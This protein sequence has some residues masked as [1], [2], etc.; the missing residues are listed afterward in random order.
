MKDSE[1]SRRI[2]IIEDNF[3]SA[4]TL[5]ALLEMQSHTLEVAYD[6]K[7]G[8]EKSSTFTPEV[9]ICDI[10]LPGDLDGYD[11]AKII[12]EN[13]R[14]K[15]I[16]LIALSGYG[17]KEDVQKAIESGFD[18]HLVKPP[19]FDKLFRLIAETEKTHE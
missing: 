5:K 14:L 1:K 7:S 4:E 11:V 13:E 9:I 15:P 3:D 6:G 18:F 12:R 2:L 16:T 19:D 8:I 10:G 17:Q